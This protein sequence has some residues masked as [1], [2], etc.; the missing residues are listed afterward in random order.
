MET[1]LPHI[2]SLVESPDFVAGIYNEETLAKIC[3]SGLEKDTEM[4]DLA[5]IISLLYAR[6]DLYAHPSLPEQFRTGWHLSRR[7]AASWAY[8]GLIHDQNDR[9]H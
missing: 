6:R 9:N 1:N 4:R 5:A 8:G 3:M 7:P 2:I